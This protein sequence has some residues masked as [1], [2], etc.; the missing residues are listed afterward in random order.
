MRSV[1]DKRQLLMDFTGIGVADDLLQGGGVV[2]DEV[3]ERLQWRRSV[4]ECLSEDSRLLDLP[5]GVG[6]ARVFVA[7]Q[8]VL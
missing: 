6:L 2:E 5:G 4:V 8:G 3:P 1:L 7:L